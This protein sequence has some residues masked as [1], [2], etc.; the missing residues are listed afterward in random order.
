M[1]RR[2]AFVS[3]NVTA[4]L[5]NEPSVKG[6][7]KLPNLHQSR[8]W[9]IEDVPLRQRTMPDKNVPMLREKTKVD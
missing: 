7:S 2:F 9:I 3:A 6:L 1:R 8:V 5:V 4:G